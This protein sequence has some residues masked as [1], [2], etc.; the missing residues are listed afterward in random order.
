MRAK[1]SFNKKMAIFLIFQ[2]I[3]VVT[4]SQTIVSGII[5]DSSNE[6]P[7]P[8]VSVTNKQTSEGTLSDAKGQF[9]I[10]CNIGDTLQIHSVGYHIKSIPVHSDSITVYLTESEN[11]LNEVVVIGYGSQSKK[12]ITTAIST[13]DGDVL[14]EQSIN[15][16]GEGLKGRIPGARIYSNNNTPGAEPVIRIRGGSSINKSNSPLIL[17][18]GVEGNLSDINPSDIKSISVLKDAASTAI[19]GSRASNGVMLVITKTGK[20]NQ[21]P[22]V[23]FQTDFARETPETSIDFMNAKDYISIVRPA[24]VNSP[25]PERNNISGYSASTGNTENSI[26]TTRFLKPGEKVPNG[27]QSMPDPLD[28][29]KTLVFQDNSFQDLLFR[30][31]LWQNDFVSVTGG[32]DKIK[33]A[34]SAGYTSDG[35][36]ALA[37]SWKRFSAR[38]NVEVKISKKLSLTSNMSYTESKML[39]YDNQKNII[40]R[41][42]ASSPTQRVYW[43]DGTPAP[44]F[45]ATSPNPI[46]Y[47]DITDQN[48]RDQNFRI[49]ESLKWKIIKGLS[50]QGN[51][52]YFTTTG[53]SDYFQKAN[54][55]NGSRNA[56]S[57]FS[58]RRQLKFEAYLTY[59]KT[60]KDHNLEFM[61]GYSY[62]NIHNKKLDAAANGGNSDKI[63]TVNGG[64]IKTDASS[65][66][67]EEK[68]L[69][70]FGRLNY[71]FKG[72]YLLSLSFREDGSSRFTT[73]H[74]WGFF[75][76][77]SAGWIVSEENFMKD[78]KPISLLKLRASYGLTGNNS[79]GLYDAQGEYSVNYRYDENGGIRSTSMPNTNLSWE[80]TKQF[81]G[82]IDL[83]LFNN[84]L[85]FTIDYYNKITQN[86]LFSK[87]LPNTSGYSSVESNIGKVKFYGFD[88]SISSTNIQTNN[89]SWNSTFTWSVNKNVVLK[90]PDN[91]RE[92]NRIG[93]VIMPDGSDYGGT[94]EG[95]SLYSFYGYKVAHIIQTQEEADNANFDELS[96][97]W[98]PIDQKSIPG[99]KSMGDYEW[100]DRN[101]DGIINSLDQF[102]LGVTQPTS[103]GGLG[104]KFSY[105]GVSLDIYLDWGL[106]H[107]IFDH[108]YQQY[109]TNTFSYNFALVNEVKKTWKGPGD[110]N[111]EYARFTPNDPGDGDRNFSRKNDG[112]TYKGDY[113]CL[114]NV[115]LGYSIPEKLLEK[116]SIKGANIYVS[117]NTLYYFTDVKGISPEFGTSSTYQ[118]NYHNYPP[119]RRFSV[120]IKVK[121]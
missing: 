86:L 88:L 16:I 40:V 22:T 75:P 65:Y 58:Q 119:I 8:A 98:S 96:H 107:S 97:G 82:G 84:K 85:N 87:K 89:F 62:L 10:D 115:T 50:V 116:Y 94:A 72:K 24:V 67:T 76:G 71:N 9:S 92:N 100:V 27:W 57:H 7:L 56:K 3:S 101:N 20:A 51:G 38:N 28:P 93:G 60:I 61:G 52:S 63:T 33:Y 118:N 80:S 83:G 64:P 53:Q 108:S 18:D 29:S 77:G 69:G 43:D 111:A 70:Y 49:Q 25:Y 47:K 5:R 32:T 11:D 36:V 68:L 1:H 121:L 117:G 54:I 106:G 95:E 26:Y 105:K 39:R 120:G 4:F 19:Y 66:I 30:P 79:I 91:G 103:T 42:L 35:G 14:Q 15:N 46:W 34:G 73:D 21:A 2:V 23:T 31:A 55:F 17:I 112:F 41:G 13:I 114:R 74:Q 48:V 12:N 45:N 109:F 104:N 102:K 37:T 59:N 113:L 90:L 78:I 99:R 81:D 6:R 44:G 110:V